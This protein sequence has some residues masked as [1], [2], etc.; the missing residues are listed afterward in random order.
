MVLSLL[1]FIERRRM[2]RYVGHFFV[3]TQNRYSSGHRKAP[4]A[5]SCL[6]CLT[7]DMRRSDLLVNVTVDV[8]STITALPVYFSC[9]TVGL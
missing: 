9:R 1:L 4:E 3:G 5:S 7:K 6:Q 2:F 8:L